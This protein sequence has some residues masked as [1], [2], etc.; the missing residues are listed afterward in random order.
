[1]RLAL[2][3]LTT[4]TVGTA[5]AMDASRTQ[6]VTR[7]VPVP[8]TRGVP[9]PLS[10]SSAATVELFVAAWCP[11]CRAL[12]AAL[13]ARQIPYT[14]YDIEHDPRGKALYERLGVRGVPV[15]RVSGQVI[16]G[17]HLDRILAALGRRL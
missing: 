6:P 8:A 11:H 9:V 14:R 7:G 16:A 15:T 17:N 4:L 5:W 13:T 1:M 3:I 12:E 10:G 2:T